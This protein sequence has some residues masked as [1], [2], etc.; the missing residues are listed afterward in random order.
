MGRPRKEN[1]MI[2]EIPPLS[3]Q[4]LVIMGASSGIGLVTARMAAARGAC[5]VLSARN[6]RDLERATR[7]I[8]ET[9]GRAEFA[10][11]DVS[12]PAQVEQ[13]AQ[14]ALKTFGRIDTW[15]NNAAVALYGR[16]VEV[17]LDDQRRQFDINYWGQ[18]H[19]C[20]TA[21]RHLREPGGTIINVAS[22]LADRAIPLQANYCAAKHALKAFTDTLRMELAADGIPVRVCLVKPGSID[23]PLFDKARTYMEL[24]PQAVPPVYAPEVS[25]R[26]ILSCAV[27][28][29]RDVIVGG[30]GKVISLAGTHAPRLTDRYMERKTIADQLSDR[31]VGEGRPDNLWS[32][33][34]YDGGER[35]GNHSGRVKGTSVYTVAALHSRATLGVVLGLA[36]AAFGVRLWRRR[37]RSRPAIAG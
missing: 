11:A 27:Q 37:R 23:T 9:G 35:G 3:E 15:I 34:A 4:V 30:M 5:V 26:A 17:S 19:G 14:V 6:A 12:D 28:P 10:A 16:A 13:V 36:T 20:L 22:A 18:V 8:R 32:P 29:R 33:V 25:A 1:C 21:V 24:E 31:P 2:R 7:E